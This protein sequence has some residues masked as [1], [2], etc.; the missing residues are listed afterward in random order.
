MKVGLIGSVGSS[1]ITLEKLVQFHFDVVGVWGY[2]PTDVKN[3]SGYCSLREF[4]NRN[5]LS[6]Y[7]FEKVNEIVVKNEIKSAC[8]DIL[9]IVGL[10]QLVDSDIVRLPR[11]GCVG[12]HPTKLPK[13]RGRAPLAWLVLREKEGAAT[14][15]KIEESAD[16]GL[17]YVQEPFDISEDDDAFSVVEKLE[18]AM[19][20]ALDSWLPRLQ[21]GDLSGQ[22][23]DKNEVTRYA[24]RT[25]LDGCI[26]WFDEA[27]K[28][29]RLIKATSH[30]HP[31]A[32]CFW[33]DWK[34][35]IWKSNWH[36]TGFPEGVV[37]RVVDL[38]NGHPVVQAGKGYLEII[39]YEVSGDD[40][41]LEKLFV[42][43]RLGYYEQLEIFK[44]K[45]E[46]RYL[47]D[48]LNQ[49]LNEK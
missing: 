21:E 24:K 27:R 16:S 19:K 14:F 31:G 9:F 3:V 13:G 20:I 42:G 26:N 29:D 48:Q 18:K 39:E 38:Y 25:P 30:P 1:L 6:Y 46:V 12:F 32:Y 4:A 15:F 8:P 33:R 45:R 23:Q 44:L 43:N 17:I 40:E 36:E 37:G 2:E 35:L 11:F 28:I 47:K 34:I 5:H 22:K 7:P 41:V 10:S 49:L